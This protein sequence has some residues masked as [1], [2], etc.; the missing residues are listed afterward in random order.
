MTA[1]QVTAV[2]TTA[3]VIISAI[4]CWKGIEHQGNR[5]ECKAAG[6]VFIVTRGDWLCVKPE[7]LI[8]IK[9]KP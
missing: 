3:F 8:D 2:L 6:G 9:E 5:T 4:A 1:S 7:I